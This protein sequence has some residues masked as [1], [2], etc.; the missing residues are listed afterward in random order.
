M[1]ITAATAGGA[2]IPPIMSAVDTHRG[3]RY[4]FSVVVAVFAFGAVLPLYTTL[5]P[6]ARRQVD[7]VLTD[8]DRNVPASKARTGPRLHLSP[9]GFRKPIPPSPNSL[10]EEA[11]DPNDDQWPTMV[12]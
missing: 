4:S 3:V 10:T 9:R 1:L 2:I 12:N 6:P 8:R 5:V 11:P 7:P